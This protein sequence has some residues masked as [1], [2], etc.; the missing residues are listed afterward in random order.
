MTDLRPQLH[1][2]TPA[3]AAAVVCASPGCQLPADDRGFG[4]CTAC[5]RV[6]RCALVLCDRLRARDLARVEH[7]TPGLT[8]AIR[9]LLLPTPDDLE[10]LNNLLSELEAALRAVGEI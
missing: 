6:Y 3:P 5:E 4:V 7:G 10:S 2:V 1:L 9:A 8:A